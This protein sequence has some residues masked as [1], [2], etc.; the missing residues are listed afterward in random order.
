MKNYNDSLTA[1]DVYAARYPFETD[2]GVACAARAREIADC[3]DEK[4]RQR[5]FYVWKLLE[6]ALMRS[7][8]LNAANVAFDKT[9]DGK[10]TCRECEFSLSHKDDLVAVAVSRSPVGIDIEKIDAER[11]DEKLQ[12]RIL[13][14]AERSALSRLAASERSLRANILWTEKEALFKRDNGKLF[15]ANKLETANS[16]CKTI[17]VKSGEVGYYLSV[18]SVAECVC[19]YNLTNV[20]VG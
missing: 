20:V 15:A 16:H 18:V 6:Y 11:F 17:I 13:T 3:S 1:V 8:G 19:S 12:A 7:L 10:W 14:P 2:G 4:T 5:K 9:A